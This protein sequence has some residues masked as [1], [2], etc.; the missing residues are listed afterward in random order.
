[1]PKSNLSRLTD[2]QINE[3]QNDV[4]GLKSK[5]ELLLTNHLPH[6]KE[7]I[8]SL[9]TRV[10]LTAALNIG[11]LILAIIAERLFR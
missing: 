10:T 4:E 5:M 11:A 7:D 3:L 1:M 9:K 2:Y 8:V 6:I